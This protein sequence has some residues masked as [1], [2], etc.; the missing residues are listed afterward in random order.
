MGTRETS[1]ARVKAFTFNKVNMPRLDQSKDLPF[2]GPGNCR[3]Y[4][5][6][7]K[8]DGFLTIGTKLDK[9]T[10]ALPKDDRFF[11]FERDLGLLL[12][13]KTL[14]ITGFRVRITYPIRF[15][16]AEINI[17]SAFLAV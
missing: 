17:D 13:Q 9:V 15:P 3:Y 10:G 5:G 16:N 12:H 8:L 6:R 14:L 11:L 2:A 7:Q 4:F 1:R